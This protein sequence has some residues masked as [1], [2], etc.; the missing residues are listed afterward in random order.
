MNGIPKET[1]IK[2]NLN[3][4]GTGCSDICTGVGFFDHML[5][6]FARHGLFNYSL[7]TCSRRLFMWTI[8][9]AQFEEYRNCTWN[10]HQKSRR[11]AKRGSAVHGSAILPMDEVLVLCALNYLSGRPY[12]SSDA[13]FQ[14]EKIGDMSQ[15]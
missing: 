10:S 5:D 1:E 4:D 13:V 15:K 2:L 14:S 9:V 6:G 7:G 11:A 3:L 8:V 12:F